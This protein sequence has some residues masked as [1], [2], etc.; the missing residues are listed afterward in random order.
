MSD[1]REAVKQLELEPR[2]PFCLETRLIEQ[3]GKV[4]VCAVCGKDW[5]IP[6]KP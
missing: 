2:C 1:F 3:V 4:W 5:A 6:Q